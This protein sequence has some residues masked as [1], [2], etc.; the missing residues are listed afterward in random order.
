M[1]EMRTVCIAG[2]SGFIGHNLV[3]RLLSE[4]YAVSVISRE[5]FKKGNVIGKIGDCSIVINLIGES[6]A[7]FWTRRKRNRIY[8]S[9][10]RTANILV[11]AINQAGN[12]VKLLIQVSG[13][14]IYDHQ[15]IHEEDSK[16]YNDDFL[17]EVIKDWEG[18]L[19]KIRK[20]NLRVIILRLGIVLDKHGG[21]LKQLMYI[22][23]WGLEL[24]LRVRSIFLLYRWMI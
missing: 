7:G 13:V 19:T 1:S 17:S 8:D 4:G 5:D 21:I 23:R 10:I 6:I 11:E 3:Q 24:V 16:N 15:H 9:R 12:D 20:D 2:A 14:G 18:E 22:L